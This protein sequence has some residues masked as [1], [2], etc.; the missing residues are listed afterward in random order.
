MFTFAST[1]ARCE[2]ALKVWI[3]TVKPHKSQT[4]VHLNGVPAK[5]MTITPGLLRSVASS[6]IRTEPLRSF[7]F[8][9]A[10][11]PMFSHC[12]VPVYSEQQLTL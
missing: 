7:I 11:E 8:Y 2:W 6:S 10:K 3:G 4:N 1:F 12:V 5:K 9:D